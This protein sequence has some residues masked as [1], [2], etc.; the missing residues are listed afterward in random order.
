[1]GDFYRPDSRRTFSEIVNSVKT[2][3]GQTNATV[4]DSISSQRVIMA[5]IQLEGN[6]DKTAEITDDIN[7]VSK[8]KAER[9]LQNP[10]KKHPGISVCQF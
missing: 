2:I 8:D 4:A 7:G 6:T 9:Q 5:K 10:L 3:S 1:M